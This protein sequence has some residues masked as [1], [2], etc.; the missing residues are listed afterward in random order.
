MQARTTGAKI[1][2]LLGGLRKFGLEVYMEKYKCSNRLFNLSLSFSLH[3][4][5]PIPLPPQL[6]A[7][8][9]FS[10]NE[11]MGHSGDRLAAAFGITRKEQDDYARRSHSLAFEANKKGLLEDLIPVNI[12][13]E[14]I[15]LSLCT[16]DRK[17]YTCSNE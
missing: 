10:T 15:Y 9:E 3:L 13:G 2:T 5:L 4:S 7:I 17:K 11:T 16:T 6:P 8:T 1:T 12:P 14:Y